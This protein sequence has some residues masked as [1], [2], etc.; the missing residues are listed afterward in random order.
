MK[1]GS[2]ILVRKPRPDPT[3]T[4]DG[5]WALDA[6]SLPVIATQLPQRPDA[7][8]MMRNALGWIGRAGAPLRVRPTDFP[9]WE[10]LSQRAQR[11]GHGGCF[12]AIGTD[13]RSILSRAQGNTGQSRRVIGAARTEQSRSKRGARAGDDDDTRKKTQRHDRRSR[14]LDQAMHHRARLRRPARLWEITSGNGPK[15][16]RFTGAAA[17][18]Q[19]HCCQCA[20][21]GSSAFSGTRRAA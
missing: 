19:E 11:W 12:D 2:R 1:T 9:H 7:V 16:Q 5:A 17:G 18:R 13:W 15:C 8:R 4:S 20:R 10:A 14:R 3:E 21:T 6:P